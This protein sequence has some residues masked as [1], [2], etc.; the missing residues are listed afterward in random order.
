MN[1][2]GRETL[3]QSICNSPCC[4]FFRWP[5]C[6]CKPTQSAYPVSPK[7]LTNRLRD[8]GRGRLG[9]LRN[10]FLRAPSR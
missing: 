1:S 7:G 8:F 6:G 9:D 5:N 10:P 3:M 2:F 4:S